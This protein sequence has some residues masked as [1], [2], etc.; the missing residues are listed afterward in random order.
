MAALLHSPFAQASH[1]A[2]KI[3][4]EK[5]ES[6]FTG[7]LTDPT[8]VEEFI[9]R[10]QLAILNPSVAPHQFLDCEL[11]KNKGELPCNSVK[12]LEFSR[13][14]VVLE[15]SGP[16]VIDLTLVDLP[17]LIKSVDAGEDENN[18]ALVDDMVK[19]Y[20]KQEESLILLVI[21]MKGR[22][23]QARSTS[24]AQSIGG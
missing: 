22:S 16:E 20:M 18:V 3:K 12:Q 1:G 14:V 24:Q 11:P 19:D 23:H 6:T 10:A 15:I 2:Q 21:T 5:P 8:K 17:G 9:R 7:P 13:N 4:G